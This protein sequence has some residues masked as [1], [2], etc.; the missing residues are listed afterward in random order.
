LTLDSLPP[1]LWKYI[2]VAYKLPS[3]RNLVIPVQQNLG[4]VLSSSPF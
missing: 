4:N 3:L 2:Y 1:E